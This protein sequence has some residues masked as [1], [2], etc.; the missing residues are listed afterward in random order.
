MLLLLPAVWL[1]L[2]WLICKMS[3]N[4]QIIT[5]LL[6]GVHFS[7]AIVMVTALS[8]LYI[9]FFVLRATRKYLEFT[10]EIA[11][12]LQVYS[13]WKFKNLRVYVVLAFLAF[14]GFQ[15]L[16]FY[17]YFREFILPDKKLTIFA[18]RASMA[19]DTNNSLPAL[20]YSIEQ[21]I[22]FVEI[23]VQLSKEG[24]PVVF[25][26]L[27]Y[28]D[29]KQN[30]Y[31]SN[32]PLAELKQ[33]DLKTKKN[34]QNPEVSIPSLEEFLKFSK[35]KIKVNIEIKTKKNFQMQL[36]ESVAEIINKLDMK[37]EVMVTSFDYAILQRVEEIVPKIQ[38]GLV[39]AAYV[40]QIEE[41]NDIDVDW[42]MV[43]DMYYALHKKQ[44]QALENKKISLWSFET[45]Y[46]GEDALYFDTVD[47]VIIDDPAALKKEMEKYNTLPP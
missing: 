29:G 18:H 10:G 35:G 21:K 15:G 7:F 4:H 5:S 41:I 24:I 19:Q 33:F 6:L 30:K 37:D 28:F 31:V 36:A 45:S 20:K 11:D 14:S 44:F 22:E 25:H 8:Y 23:D 34:T 26:D 17:D 47:G 3:M 12:T 42:L 46:T 39:V 1:F 38:T 32:T 27:T 13:S 43:N 2:T 9:S 40:G 16:V